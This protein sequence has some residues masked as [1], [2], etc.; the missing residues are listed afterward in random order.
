M[1]TWMR[2]AAQ[3]IEGGQQTSPI[4]ARQRVVKPPKPSL[5]TPAEFAA[6]LKKSRRAAAAF[7]A[8]SPSCQREYVEWVAD[9]KRA[10][11]R[12]KRI[13]TAVAWIAE[14]KKRNWK[15]E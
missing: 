8:F 4:A 2:Q 14:G 12:T 5:K 6:A 15:Y 9:A 11:T 10:E 13:E 1:L 7:A 3:F